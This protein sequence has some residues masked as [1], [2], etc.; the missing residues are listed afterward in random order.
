MVRPP[1]CIGIGHC[2]CL[3]PVI[4]PRLLDRYKIPDEGI[5][6]RR[7]RVAAFDRAWTVRRLVV[8]PSQLNK[9]RAHPVER[10]LEDAVIVRGFGYH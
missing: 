1:K 2:R 5:I 6:G 9:P 7:Q 4:V 10:I 8:K 3:A